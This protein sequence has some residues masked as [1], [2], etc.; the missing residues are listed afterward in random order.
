MDYRE[1]EPTATE[2]EAATAQVRVREEKAEVGMEEG[3][4][5]RKAML[6]A[7]R[8]PIAAAAAA[9]GRRLASSSTSARPRAARPTATLV[10]LNVP[11]RKL[12]KRNRNTRCVDIYS[13]GYSPNLNL[14]QDTRLPVT[15]RPT[16]T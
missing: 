9:A 3:L 15:Q 11:V 1:E 4:A 10:I 14:G 2:V 13:L 6:A 16:D 8:A 12:R 7:E 5:M